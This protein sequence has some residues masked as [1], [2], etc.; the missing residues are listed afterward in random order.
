MFFLDFQLL[1]LDNQQSFPFLDI[2]SCLKKKHL[3]IRIH[4]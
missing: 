1:V 2:I 4:I 3:L